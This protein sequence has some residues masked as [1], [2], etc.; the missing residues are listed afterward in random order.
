MRR[1]HRRLAILVSAIGLAMGLAVSGVSAQTATDAAWKVVTDRARIEGKAVFYTNIGPAVFARLKEGFEKAYP[2][3][4]VEPVRLVGGALVS[5]VDQERTTGADGADMLIMTDV[6]W[7]N[8]R[9]KENAA[10]FK[11]PSGPASKT[12]PANYMLSGVAPILAIEPFVLLYNS[13]LVTGKINEL[14]DVLKPEFRGKVGTQELTSGTVIAWYDWMEKAGG[15]DFLAK[16]AAQTPRL[17]SSAVPIAQSIASGEIAISPYA[18]PSI[19]RPLLDQ[20]AP[21]RIVNISP[22]F[23]SG[24]FSTVFAWAKRPSTAM[25]FLDYLMSPGGQVAWNGRGDSA[26]VLAGI[27]GALDAGS[28]SLYD[29]TPYTPEV[30]KAYTDKWNKLFKARP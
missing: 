12:W 23:G 4:G 25:V 10:L 24:F 22:S 9:V 19:A 30:M 18:I 29:P 26:S 11:V 13:N 16:F 20:C 21:V 15:P 28:I 6:G 3:L 5:K 7:L 8:A 14:R 17:Y 2:G 27:A 1:H